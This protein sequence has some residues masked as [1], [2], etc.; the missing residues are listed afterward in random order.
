MLACGGAEG[1]RRCLAGAIVRHE[2]S[3][4]RLV[5]WRAA[6]PKCDRHAN[7][8]VQALDAAGPPVT[9]HAH[10]ECFSPFGQAV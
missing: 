6:A 3:P 4:F 5:L 8:H 7:R 9:A 1:R 2:V 10:P